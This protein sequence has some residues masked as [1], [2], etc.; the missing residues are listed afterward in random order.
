MRRLHCDIMRKRR[1]SL[2]SK[3]TLATLFTAVLL[4]VPA[5]RAQDANVTLYGRLNV[6]ME[7]VNGKQ[8][9]SACPDKCPDPNV[10][11]VSSNS[12]QFG[13]RGAE[14]LGAG[15]AAIF[16]IES[17]VSMTEGRGILAGRESFVGLYG[18]LGTFKM[19]Y[20]LGPY[21]DILPIFGNVPTLTSS[22]LSTASLWAQG[23]LGPPEAGGFDDRLKNSIRYDTPR[24]SGLSASIQYATNDG[25]PTPGSHN[26]S[27]GAFYADGPVQVGIAYELHSKIRGTPEAPLTD[28]AFSIAGGYQFPAVRIS[29]VYERLAYDATTTTR[30]KRD[31]Y[32]IGATA[33][34]GPGLMYAFVGRAGNGTGSADSRKGK[35]RPRPSGKSATPM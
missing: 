1:L 26:L 25:A 23:F 13:I 20:F 8:A 32:G 17:R 31:F 28:H 22:I 16:Q 11:R 35:A 24:I 33:D 18:P 9:G 14:P 4:A 29:A 30:L 19:G 27:T 21:D 34:V 15:V 12:S 5:V 10:F 2:T 6:D 7:V 3:S